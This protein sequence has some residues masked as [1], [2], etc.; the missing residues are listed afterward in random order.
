MEEEEKIPDND[1]HQP[2]L[3]APH[4]DKNDFYL[5]WI[6][7]RRFFQYRCLVPGNTYTIHKDY[8]FPRLIPIRKFVPHVFRDAWLY[9]QV[10]PLISG[11]GARHD[12]S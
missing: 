1:H 3:R 5:I 9:Y 2:C 11:G 4:D 10:L 6:D 12:K 7:Q 8:V